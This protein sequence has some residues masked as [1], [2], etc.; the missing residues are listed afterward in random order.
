M[1][2]SIIIPS[3]GPRELNPLSPQ[4]LCNNDIVE[5]AAAG[6]PD[7]DQGGGPSSQQYS[8]WFFTF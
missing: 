6:L 8:G 2:N 7:D 1:I 3:Q 5:R 4:R